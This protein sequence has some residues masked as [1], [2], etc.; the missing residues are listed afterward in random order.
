MGSIRKYKG[1][2][3]TTYRAEVYVN[4]VRRSETLPTRQAA[5][6]WVQQAEAELAGDS[7]PQN[8]V[9][10]ALNRYGNEVSPSHKGED[11]ELNRIKAIS[12]LPLADIRLPALKASDLADWRDARGATVGPAT[13]LREMNFLHG[14]FES[15]RR[16]W[17]WLTVNPLKEVRRPRNPPSR[18]RRITEGEVTKLV[19]ALG[20]EG[21]K[22]ANLSQRVALAFL[23][24]LETAMRSGEIVGLQWADVGPH[25]VH[26]PK[27]KNGDARDVALSNEARRLLKLLPKGDGPVFG[28]HTSQRDA[29]FRKARKKAGVVDLHFHDARAEAIWRLSGKLNVMELARM[30][31]HRDLNSLLIYYQTSAAELSAKLDSPASTRQSPSRPSAGRKARAGIQA[32]TETSD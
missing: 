20:Y 10:Q 9:R 11:W 12:K 13:V 28:L 31:G 24:S 17:G 16:D 8:T 2:R 6:A 29:L 26:L 7:L 32:R 21:G 27:T 19:T 25:S 30:I 22:P 3:V 1:R 23:F 5:V 4:G 15:C 14:V 18:K